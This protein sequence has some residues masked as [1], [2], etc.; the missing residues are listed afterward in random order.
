MDGL[1][2]HWTDWKNQFL[3]SGTFP[4]TAPKYCVKLEEERML[5][6]TRGHSGQKTE[7]LIIFSDPARNAFYPFCR[8]KNLDTEWS[9][10]LEK[11]STKPALSNRNTMNHRHELEMSNSHT[12]MVKRKRW[13]RTHQYILFKPI[14][15]LYYNFNMQSITSIDDMFSFL[16]LSLQYAAWTGHFQPISLWTSRI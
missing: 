8:R 10:N 2:C 15:P 6:C 9:H 3:E 4:H 11:P 12:K 16:V 1:R 5:I 14:D 7:C 13:N